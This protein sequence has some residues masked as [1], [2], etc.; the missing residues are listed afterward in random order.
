[1]LAYDILHD[2]TII[3]ELFLLTGTLESLYAFDFSLNDDI[4]KSTGWHLYDPDTEYLRMGVPNTMWAL[5]NMN[6]NYEVR[7]IIKLYTVNSFLFVTNL[8]PPHFYAS[9]F[10]T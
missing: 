2:P 6:K 9:E 3:Y 7:L 4:P 8:N 1:M 5:T 10:P